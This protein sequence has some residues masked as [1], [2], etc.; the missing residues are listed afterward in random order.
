MDS[1]PPIFARNLRVLVEY[2]GTDFVGWQAQDNG[3]SV[4]VACEQALTQ[5]TQVK[6]T[7]RVAG[8]TDA[9]V[10][11][12]AQVFNFRSD[13]KLSTKR[14]TSGLNALLPKSITVH[15]VEDVPQAFD[16]K[17]DSEWKRYCYS[18][19][20]APQPAAHLHRRAWHL[21]SPLDMSAIRAAADEL[22][23]QHDFESF[24]AAGCQAKHANRE[25]FDI[26]I[27]RHPRPPAGEL[28]TI[29]YRAD[30]FCR[31]MCRI[32]TGTLV[33]VGRGE[34]SPISMRDVLAARSRFAAGVT[35]PAYGLCLLQVR[36]PEIAPLAPASG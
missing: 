36:Y 12:V 11:A 1:G 22:T 18:I 7:V 10:H 27:E 26:T 19:Y 16:S 30:A 15:A 24:R 5:L 23:G 13:T 34:R 17:R 31:H 28:V 25:M 3:P 35:A 32:L 4:Q 2:D 21:I 20:Q 33:E 9:G 14:L 6:P 8:R 29:T